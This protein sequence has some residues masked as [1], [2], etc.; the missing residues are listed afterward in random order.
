ML[1]YLALSAHANK[2]TML[3]NNHNMPRS[4]T[5]ADTARQLALTPQLQPHPAIG[6][7]V[8]CR[9]G[10]RY[11]TSPDARAGATPRRSTL[12]RH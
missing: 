3:F 11:A 10:R 2:I 7:R 8:S 5:A 9:P 6:P 4:S 1:R 12:A